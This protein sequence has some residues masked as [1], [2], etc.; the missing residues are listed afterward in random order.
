[1]VKPVLRAGRL[2]DARASG[3]TH[4]ADNGVPDRTRAGPAGH[5][6]VRT[7][8]NRYVKPDVEDLR[9]AVTTWEGLHGS[10]GVHTGRS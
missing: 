9:T 1:M 8:E 6:D 2:Y 7:T 10:P 5:C 4:L 3:F